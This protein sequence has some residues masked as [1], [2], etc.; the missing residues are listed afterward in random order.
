MFL[1]SCLP[2]DEENLV[3]EGAEDFKPSEPQ[4]KAEARGLKPS[5]FFNLIHSFG[6][7]N[8]N[9]SSAAD[10]NV[11][12]GRDFK[13]LRTASTWTKLSAKIII[14]QMSSVVPYLHPESPHPN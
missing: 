11:S 2:D 3:D 8:Q 5:F 10:I 13:G 7:L 12:H 6:K 1:L 4:S 9:S 14:V